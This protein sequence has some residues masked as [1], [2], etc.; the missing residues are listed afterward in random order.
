MESLKSD[1]ISP[2]VNKIGTVMGKETRLV[3]L[4]GWSSRDRVSHSAHTALTL[5]NQSKSTGSYRHG[6]YTVLC[7]RISSNLQMYDGSGSMNYS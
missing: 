4:P 5:D 6:T 7:S 1:I 3:G 2:P